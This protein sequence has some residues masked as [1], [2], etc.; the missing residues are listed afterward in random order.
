MAMGWALT[1]FP[2]NQWSPAG[3]SYSIR[4]EDLPQVFE[5]YETLAK[6]I[7][8]RKKAGRNFHFFHFI[9]DLEQGALRHQTAARLRLRERICGGHA[10]TETSTP[11]I[12]LSGEEEWKM[13][14]L[15]DGTFDRARKAEFA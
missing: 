9:I 1:S 13:G 11:A 7:I 3:L 5:E 4:E 2:L 15:V 6:T 10:R 12:S 14:S 8:K